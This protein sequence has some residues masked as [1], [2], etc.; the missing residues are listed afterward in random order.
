MNKS[1]THQFLE[2]IASSALHQES[3]QPPTTQTDFSPETQE[4]Q[5]TIALLLLHRNNHPCMQWPQP[6]LPPPPP[7][8]PF[9]N[10]LPLQLTPDQEADLEVEEGI[11]ALWEEVLL[12]PLN[13][14]SAMHWPQLFDNLE[15]EEVEAILCLEAE[16]AEAPL[17]EEDQQ[18]QH[19]RMPHKY[20]LPQWLTPMQWE[21]PHTSSK[22]KEDKPETL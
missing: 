9:P 18:C 6:P 19:L 2:T 14:E 7:P 1:A 16:E 13:S 12:S 5:K 8:P 22:E 21:H 4:L 11:A 10:Q 15:V 20:L 17:E 3:P